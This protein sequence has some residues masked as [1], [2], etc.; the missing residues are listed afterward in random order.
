MALGEKTGGKD[1]KQ[2]QSGNPKGRPKL[3]EDVKSCLKLNQVEF[4]RLANEFLFMSAKQLKEVSE[5]HEETVFRQILAAVLLEAI[6]NGDH[7]RLEFFI[8]R[9]I[10]K[11][12]QTEVDEPQKNLHCEIVRFIQSTEKNNV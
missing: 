4:V 2:G 12:K 6:T 5:N 8:D 7:K 3:P 9:L 1:F 10:G 11:S